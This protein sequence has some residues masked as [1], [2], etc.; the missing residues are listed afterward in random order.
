[1]KARATFAN[2]ARIVAGLFAL[3]CALAACLAVPGGV[4][5][6]YAEVSAVYTATANPSYSNPDTGAVEDAGGSAQSALGTSMVQSITGQQAYVE[7]DVDG[8]VFLTLRMAQAAEVGAVSI[9]SDVDHDGTFDEAQPAQVMK[10][11]AAENKVDVRAR[12]AGEQATLRVN[13]YVNAMGRE[14][15]YFVT[16]SDMREGNA[17][18]FVETVVPGEA[19]AAAPS[20][21]AGAS[22]PAADRAEDQQAAVAEG[23]AASGVKEYTGDGAAVSGSAQNDAGS[24]NYPA[25]VGGIVLVAVLGSVA[26]YIAVVRPRR[27]AQASAAAAAAE[28]AEDSSRDA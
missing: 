3:C 14:V 26:A 16:L 28:S 24:L 23:A 11:D 8:A 13:M 18:G 20:A 9:A 1:M 17:A 27:A 5:P 15:V 2:Q 6:A 4:E 21:Q 25:I 19:G 10:N 7:K 22:E 12:I